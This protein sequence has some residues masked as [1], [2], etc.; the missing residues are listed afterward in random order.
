M[1]NF[2]LNGLLQTNEYIAQKNHH[3]ILMEGQLE[4]KVAQRIRHVWALKALV[5]LKPPS[6][7]LNCS[8]LSKLPLASM[9]DEWK[10]Q[11]DDAQQLLPSPRLSSSEH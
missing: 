4:L 7:N 10:C 9:L 5:E 6:S 2:F 8:F 3:E 1:T 11:I